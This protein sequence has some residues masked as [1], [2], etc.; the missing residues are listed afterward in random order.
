MTPSEI[1]ENK[2]QIAELL[3]RYTWTGDFGDADGFAGCFTGDGVL[4]V[5]GQA[6]YAGRAAI[7]A[8]VRGGP[9]APQ[10]ASLPETLSGPLHHHVS[11]VRIEIDDASHARVF[12]YFLAMGPH[13][14]DHWGRY[15]DRVERVDGA[16]LFRYRR[17]SADGLSPHALQRE[18]EAKT[19]RPG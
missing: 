10:G 2:R 19:Q 14:P 12:A 18:L 3:A 8:M 5:K 17:A 15:S 16:W 11:S 13:G 7:A 4:D 1:V 9:H 6:T